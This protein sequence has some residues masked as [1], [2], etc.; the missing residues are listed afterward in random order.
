MPL[1]TALIMLA[2][3]AQMALTFIV[4]IVMVTGRFA[5]VRSREMRA[6]QYILVEGEPARL[7][8]VTNSLRNQFELPVIFYALVL[9][10]VAINRVTILDV[11]LAW[12]FV[13]ARI[14]HV[15]LHIRSDNVLLRSRI[16][17]L[18]LVVVVLLALHGAVIV[19]AEA[20]L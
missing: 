19:A 3:L 1:N 4:Y 10:F 18:G 14:V 20:F 17:G 15:T 5:A 11:L 6:A 8:R 2:M 16:F 12:A 13:A 7:A 9:M